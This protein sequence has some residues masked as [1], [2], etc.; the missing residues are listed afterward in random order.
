MRTSITIAIMSAYR[1]ALLLLALADWRSVAAAQ[2]TSVP[3]PLD[4]I[5]LERSPCFSR[6]AA[7]RLKVA[8]NGT[9]VF[10]PRSGETIRDS[11]APAV[12]V[13]LRDQAEAATSFFVGDN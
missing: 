7:Y 5:T 10:V 13:W 8:R 12:L 4:S 3:L 11:I 6:C 9:I 2:P 1:R